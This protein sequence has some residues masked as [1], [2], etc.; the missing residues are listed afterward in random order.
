MADFNRDQ[1][2]DPAVDMDVRLLRPGLI[3]LPNLDID[4]LARL[5]A[6]RPA[7]VTGLLDS[8]DA[9]TNGALDEAGLSRLVVQPGAPCAVAASSV[10]MRMH[11]DDARRVRV[12][13][14]GTADPVLGAGK[15]AGAP[16]EHPLFVAPLV[17]F[18]FRVEALTLPGDPLLAAPAG[19]APPPPEG[20]LATLPP[21][22]TNATLGTVRAPA[23]VWI[24][25][26]HT[27]PPP[28]RAI[29]DV[30]LITISPWI[31]TDNTLP[32][33]KL[34][35]VYFAA[36]S[37]LGSNHATIHDLA[38][39]AQAAFGGGVPL[40]P[41]LS[42]D[43][44]PQPPASSDKFIIIDGNV[45]PDQWVQD[46]LQF[47]YCWAPHAYLHVAVHLK[48]NRPVGA[49]VRGNLAERGVGVWEG[50]DPASGLDGTDYG[51]NLDVSP[52]VPTATPA[53]AASA[54]GPAIP[55]HAAAPL[56]K[57]LVG[58]GNPR[59]VHADFHNFLVAQKVQP[60]LPF[61]TSWL[62]V[63]H[64]DEFSAIIPS[65]GHSRKFKVAFSSVNAMTKLLD[66]LIAIPVSS[67][68]GHFHAGR[69]NEHGNYA[70]ES[71]EDLKAAHGVF[72]DR[73]RR[74][75]L[76][77][78]QQRFERG[79]ALA[80]DQILPL[81]NYFITPVAPG[82]PF[83][84]PNNRTV[85]HNVGSVNMQVINGH[86]L[87]PR[88]F[89]PRLP[90]AQAVSFVRTWLNQLGFSAVPVVTGP[91]GS[92][93]FWAWPGLRM[94]DLSA[95]FVQASDDAERNS[96]IAF[97]RGGPALAASTSAKVSALHAQI[98]T[99]PA[100]VAGPPTIAAAMDATL[101]FNKWF[102]VEV[103]QDT[104]DVVEV[105]IRSL[106][107]REGNRVHFIDDW[108]T[109]HIQMGEVHC[110]TKV[111]RTPHPLVNGTMWWDHYDPEVNRD[112]VPSTSL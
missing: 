95:F 59:P 87:I 108:D 48:R 6:P 8:S 93:P 97:L 45:F 16:T 12:F 5:P 57:I 23:D 76:I 26:D 101:T 30:A 40:P 38:V 71:A 110:G 35:A 82:L 9:V 28:L 32:A 70:E 111:C 60:V 44:V 67:G 94:D 78:L 17:N 98:F 15:P 37:G 62:E 72:N 74:L 58:D 54:G 80:A 3:V 73:L 88:P 83:G 46:E 1:R 77:P 81:P 79:L 107:E 55:A 69:Y 2:E 65:A 10:T 56:G 103:P 61:D 86:L 105:Y 50:L 91:V 13:Q 31:L 42:T 99:F 7:D 104:L 85:A 41:D 64:I 43:F 11:T 112:Y 36:S 51:G 39:A 63:G 66:A 68:R 109:Y 92:F 27:V 4:D 96:I 47:G 20:Y 24:E 22:A 25:L 102:R 19:A 18:Q 90:R 100:N 106:L 75:K 21:G 53:I 33:E 52:P 84:S 14:V 89:G 49:W 29:R 34:Y